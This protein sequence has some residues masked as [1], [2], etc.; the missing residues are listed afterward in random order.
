VGIILCEVGL[1]SGASVVVGAGIGWVLAEL[2]AIPLGGSFEWAGVVVSSMPGR[3]TWFGSFWTPVLI[4]LSS[5]LSGLWPAR[6]AAR[7]D[8]LAALR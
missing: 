3:N 5:L 1:L 4:F 6:R 7:L 2:V 8:P